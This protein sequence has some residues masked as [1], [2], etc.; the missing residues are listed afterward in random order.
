[1]SQRRG[2]IT[3]RLT[4]VIQVIQLG[5]KTGRLMVERGEGAQFEDG[6]LFF[7]CGQ[8]TDAR[9]GNLR[10]AAAIDWLRTWGK[11]RFI[12]GTEE[13]ERATSPQPLQLNSDPSP[14]LHSIPC[15]TK[16]DV[17]GMH[18]LTQAGLSRVH[19]RLYLLIDGRRNIEELMRLMR[20][21]PAVVL[22]HLEDLRNIGIIYY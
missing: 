3:D 13:S 11:C 17:V 5:K 4:N 19:L 18:I 12:F 10:G 7:A 22:Q 6:V 14:T 20:C 16:P 8:I 1:M 15:R 9:S 2:I 21:S